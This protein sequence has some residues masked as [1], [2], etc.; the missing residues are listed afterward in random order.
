[1]AFAC[2]CKGITEKELKEELAK[3]AKPIEHDKIHRQLGGNDEN[4]CKSCRNSNSNRLFVDI[5]NKHNLGV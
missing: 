2:A 4:C 1:M 5:V 3:V